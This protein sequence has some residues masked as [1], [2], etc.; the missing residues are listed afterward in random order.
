MS[1][2]EDLMKR[3]QEFPDPT[4]LVFTFPSWQAAGDAIM[5][6]SFAVKE[7]GPDVSDRRIL[8][9]IF[10]INETGE[11]NVI[12]GGNMSTSE[13]GEAMTR[14]SQSGQMRN[15]VYPESKTLKEIK[16]RKK[17]KSP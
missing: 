10:V 14:F 15:A 4:L 11:A 7:L 2:I 8:W 16:K 1:E 3:I 13:R 5:E 9:K 6:L 17:K 12:I